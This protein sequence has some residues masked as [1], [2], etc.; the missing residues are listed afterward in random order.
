MDWARF[1]CKV[2]STDI[3]ERRRKRKSTQVALQTMNL[4]TLAYS[5]HYKIPHPD[6]Y[7]KLYLIG[8]DIT[9]YRAIKS[10]YLENCFEMLISIIANDE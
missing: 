7:L 9:S 3:P 2:H 6:N 5:E 8:S 10:L 4:A 1:E